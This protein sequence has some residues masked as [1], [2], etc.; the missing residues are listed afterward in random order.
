MFF[1]DIVDQLHQRDSLTHAGTPEQPDLAAL[2][3]RHDQIDDFDAC[4]EE[5]SRCRLFLIRRRLPVYRKMFLC[6]DVARIVDRSAENVH[7]S[8]ERLLTDR[9]GDRLAGVR[10]RQPSLQAL[11]G[12]HCDCADD[13]VAELLLNL[14]RQFAIV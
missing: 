2:G 11:T 14:E 12:A 10:D 3:N 4:L 9:D 6:A 13:S 5:L 8:A 7:D 1:R